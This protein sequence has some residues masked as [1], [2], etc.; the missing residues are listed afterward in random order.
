MSRGEQRDTVEARPETRRVYSLGEE[1]ANAITH[2]LG[3]VLSV[4]AL[5]LL[6]AAAAIW[7][8]AWHLASAV[9][10]GLTLFVLYLSSTLY[11]SIQHERA[12]RVFKIIDHASIYLLIAGT[13]TPFTLVTL[14]DHGGW[15]LFAIV[16]AIAAGGVVLEAVAVD[17]PTWLSVPLY[18]AMGW[19]V[20]AVIRPLVA[21]VPPEGLWLLVA[22]GLAYTVGTAFYVAKRLPYTHMVW[23]LFVLTG[24]LCHF[25]AVMLYVL[26]LPR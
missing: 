18:L 16:W 26:P 7:G 11:H 9:V 5:T 1:I 23:H 6:V 10:Y 2:G 8:N 15:Y 14:R 3:T 4:A 17:R 24:S 25:L 19:L 22:G 13:Y 21:T 12:K 20:I